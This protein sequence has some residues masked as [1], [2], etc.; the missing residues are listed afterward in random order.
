[1]MMM[2]MTMTMMCSDRYIRMALLKSAKEGISLLNADAVNKKI[3]EPV[4]SGF[5]DT[6][7][8]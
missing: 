8:K 6:N 1:M 5:S 2:L 7:A 3:F 4:L